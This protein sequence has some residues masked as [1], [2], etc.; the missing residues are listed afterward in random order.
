MGVLRKIYNKIRGVKKYTIDDIS[1]QTKEKI[2]NGG[3]KVGENVDIYFSDIDLHNPYMINIGN[4]V[5]ITGVKILTHD[6][7]LKKTIGYSKIG[8]IHIGNDVF[9]G[10]GTIILPNTKIGN[11]VVIG[12]GS[13]ISK[14][15]PD[16]SVVVGNPQ[17][18]ICS[19]DDYVNKTK[20]LMDEYPIIDLLPSEILENEESIEKLKDKGF[21]YIL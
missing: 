11:K 6:A 17:Q 21:G 9:I 1:N 14:D 2:I 4:N 13:V 8:K 5:T 19:Y 12:A 18:I 3:G 20:K 7:S 16:N 15:I 10:W